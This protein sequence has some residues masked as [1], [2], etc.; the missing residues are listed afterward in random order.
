[1]LISYIEMNLYFVKCLTGNGELRFGI[2]LSIAVSL[3]MFSFCVH[4]YYRA[5][6]ALNLL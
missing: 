6:A 3:A 4:D 2:I 1:M 5:S